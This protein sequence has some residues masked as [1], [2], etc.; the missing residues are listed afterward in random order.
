MSRLVRT[1][2]HVCIQEYT[3]IPRNAVTCPAELGGPSPLPV[4]PF[5]RRH[6]SIAVMPEDLLPG[7]TELLSP[8]I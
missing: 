3:R 6:E 1:G 2:T 4:I 8:H 5:S 7:S